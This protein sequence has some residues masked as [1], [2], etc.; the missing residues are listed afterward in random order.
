LA[1][2]SDMSRLICLDLLSRISC[3]GWPFPPV[4]F[5]L[6]FPGCPDLA[7]L[8]Q[9][10]CH[11]CSVPIVLSRLLFSRCPVHSVKLWLSCPLFPFIVF[12]YQPSSPA[13]L[14]W[15]ACAGCPIQVLLCWLFYPGSHAS[16]PCPCC[17]ILSPDHPLSCPGGSVQDA[18]SWHYSTV[19]AD[20]LMLSC[21]SCSYVSVLSVSQLVHLLIHR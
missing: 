9:L 5:Q 6:S 11:G 14:S 16:L 8:S 12:L 2:C 20:L 13:V 7:F 21:P 17:N 18:L 15:L 1:C 3:L 19:L 4:L 10:S